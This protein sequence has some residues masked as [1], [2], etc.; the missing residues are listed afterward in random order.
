MNSLGTP[1]SS[2]SPSSASARV[3]EN[4]APKTIGERSSRMRSA[5][6]VQRTSGVD[7]SSG[8]AKR[9]LGAGGVSINAGRT[10]ARG[11]D[12]SASRVA[13]PFEPAAKSRS[14]RTLLRFPQRRPQ[15]ARGERGAQVHHGSG[16]ARTPTRRAARVVHS[17]PHARPTRCVT[18]T[19]RLT[20]PADPTS[21][22]E[23]HLSAQQAQAR[24]DARLPKAHEHARGPSHP[25]APAPARPQ[26]PVGLGRG[27]NRHAQ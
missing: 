7:G 26:A 11:A 25:Q 13:R 9:V 8:M 22:R 23:A 4:Q 16:I 2:T 1:T 15:S 12:A 21:S 5:T 24:Q 19:L 20:R 3:V 10:G 14:L 27:R 17:V 18:A 6:A